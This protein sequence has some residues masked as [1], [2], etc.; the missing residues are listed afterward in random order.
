MAETNKRTH[1]YF[2]AME[3]NKGNHFQTD[4]LTKDR[5]KLVF[6]GL[7]AGVGLASCGLLADMGIK[8]IQIEQALQ[9][10]NETQQA[11]SYYFPSASTSENNP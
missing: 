5:L 7:I 6:Y 9:Q 1:E 4:G 11:D 10:A 8:A 2:K 3:Q